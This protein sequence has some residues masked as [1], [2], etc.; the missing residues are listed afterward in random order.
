ME[1]SY[2]A[3]GRFQN[4][5]ARFCVKFLLLEYYNVSALSI[6]AKWEHFFKGP[7]P[8]KHPQ[9]IINKHNT[10]KIF[11]RNVPAREHLQNR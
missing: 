1:K 9:R 6:G 5:P 8:P 2:S 10:S 11:F 7:A 4:V 3:R